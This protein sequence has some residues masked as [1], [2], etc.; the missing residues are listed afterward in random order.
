LSTVWLD[1]WAR[2]ACRV[3]ARADR[4]AQIVRAAYRLIAERGLEGLRFA[5]VA[6]AAGI[7]NGTLLYYFAGKDAL[8]QAVG[9]YLVDQF[10]HSGPARPD[11]VPHTPLADLRWEFTDAR[12]RLRDTTAVV[13]LE[14]LARAQRDPTVA[15]LLRDIDATWH[16]WLCRLL[17]AGR[18][19][20]SLRA[21]VDVDLMATM[22]MAA[23]RGV[24]IQALVA[25]EP[26]VGPA[27]DAL[28]D[29]IERWL[30]PPS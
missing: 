21:D 8:I 24:G 1:E 19:D 3:A 6:R 20:G 26:D 17:E 5:D 23:I 18:R 12:A 22:A 15:S 2:Y 10:R 11:D 29:L 9:D 14:L 4:R 27:L 13:Y 7:N 28:A 16:G 30:A 25:P